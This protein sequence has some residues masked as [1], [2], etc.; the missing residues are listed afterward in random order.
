MAKREQVVEEVVEETVGLIA[1]AFAAYE[2]LMNEIHEY[3]QK[4]RELREQAAELRQS[5]RTDFEVGVEVQQLLDQAKHFQM[6]ADQKYDIPL[7]EALRRIDNLEREASDYR[8]LV[9]HNQSVLARQQKELQEARVEAAAMIQRA[10]ERVRET[11]QLLANELAKLVE[12]EGSKDEYLH[13]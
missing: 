1:Q 5:G 12:L 3:S 2:K 9:K 6:L 8:Q 7:L 13:T 11:S 10:E 4:A